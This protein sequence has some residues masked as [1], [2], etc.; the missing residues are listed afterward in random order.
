L[1]S[2]SVAPSALT[3]R[4]RRLTPAGLGT[5]L[6]RRVAIGVMLVVGIT[7]VAFILTHLVPGDPAAANLGQRA[8]ADPAAVATFN[9][10]YGLDKPVPEQYLIYLGHLVRGDLGTSE[11]SHRAVTRDLGEYVPATLELALF[12]IVGCVLFGV[13]LGIVAAMRRGRIVDGVLRILSLV[14]V[15]VPTFWLA[16]LAFYLLFYRWGWFPSGGRLNPGVSPPGH[17]TGLYTLDALLEGRWSLF[18]DA[19]EHLILPSFVLGVYTVGLILRFT[20]ASVLEI[21]GNDYV[22]SARAKGLTEWTVIRRHVMRPALVSIATIFGVAFGSLLS[23]TV[24]VE[25]IFSWPGIGQYAYN[26]AINLDLP[27]IMGV[28]MVVAVFYI[29]L[30]LAVDVFYSILD[31]RIELR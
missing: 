15:S 27:A 13:A 26:S 25:S 1:T 4:A 2:A 10:K 24:L 28:S 17:T 14:G 11:Q 29:V 7:L 9:H 8:I 3:R 22:R 5:F 21:L 23:G 16:L 31:P 19:F 18:V 6:I 12:A 30:N 20:R